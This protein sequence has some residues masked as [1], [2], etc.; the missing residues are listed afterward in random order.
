MRIAQ[1]AQRIEPFQV[2]EVA[3]AAADLARAQKPDAPQIGRAH[4]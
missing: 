1:R 3:K 2:M 4:V